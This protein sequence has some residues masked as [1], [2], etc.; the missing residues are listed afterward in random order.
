MS[1]LNKEVRTDVQPIADQRKLVGS[2][3]GVY[4]FGY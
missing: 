4:I 2:E 1:S 3:F